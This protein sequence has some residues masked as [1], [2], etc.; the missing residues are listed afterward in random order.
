MPRGGSGAST[1][2]SLWGGCGAQ[3]P[4]LGENLQDGERDVAE[5]FGGDSR[6]PDFRGARFSGLHL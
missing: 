6:V 5:L 3:G 1:A 2:P 4:Q